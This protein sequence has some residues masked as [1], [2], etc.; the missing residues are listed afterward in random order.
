M[1]IAQL[2]EPMKQSNKFN[3]QKFLI[4]L[5]QNGYKERTFLIFSLKQFHDFNAE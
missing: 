5:R 4:I 1:V 2:L 3:N